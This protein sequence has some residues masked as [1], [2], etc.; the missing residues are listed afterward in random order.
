ML[1]RHL[2]SFGAIAVAVVLGGSVRAQSGTPQTPSP[3]PDPKSGAYSYRAFCAS[4]H[5]ESGRG[6]GVV[7][8]VLR[9]RPA[10]LTTIRARRQGVFPREEIVAIV[11][12][13]TEVAGHGPSDMPVWGDSLLVLENRDPK[14]VGR[15]IDALVSYLETIQSPGPQ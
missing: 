13:R 15:R 1:K 4:C 5:G 9:K 2:L 10:D 8:D 12:G 14:A 6:D 3:H 7:A 11:S